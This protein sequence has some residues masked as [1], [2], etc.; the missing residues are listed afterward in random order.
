MNTPVLVVATPAL[1]ARSFAEMVTAARQAP[2]GLRWATSGQ[3]TTGHLVL[4]QVCAIAGVDITHVPYTGG[5]QQINDA[6]A[7]HFE[8]L[9]SNVAARQL[10]YV[11][12]G[13]L[14]ALA[15]GA[16]QRLPAL[17]DVPTLGELGYAAANLSSLF[18]V[19]ASGRTAGARLDALA[20]EL[21]AVLAQGS[22]RQ[23]ILAN[24]N[25]PATLTRAE[26]VG[27]IA[28]ERAALQR[29]LAA[30]EAGRN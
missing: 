23:R 7:G 9:S 12:E 1:Q 11:R 13:R 15:V 24:G 27:H 17:P 19:F 10:A 8:L 16:P 21:N 26:F 30:P 25:L 5:G 29:L 18:G 2:G 22:F 28:R 20:Q 3:G 6:L 4:R 14:R